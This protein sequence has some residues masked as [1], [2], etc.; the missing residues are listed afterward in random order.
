MLSGSCN[1]A[2]SWHDIPRPWY[3]P[4]KPNSMRQSYFTISNGQNKNKTTIFEYEQNHEYNLSHQI[5]Y[6]KNENDN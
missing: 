3:F 1:I 6:I 2:R 4:V 5:E